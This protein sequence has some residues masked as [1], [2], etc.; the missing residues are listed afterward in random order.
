MGK[1]S[2]E[3]FI[4]AGGRTAIA[5][6]NKGLKNF[7]AAQMAATVVADI[8]RRNEIKKA[9][10]SEV[11][12]GN[13]VSAG[14][15]QNIARQVIALAQLPF[16]IPAYAVNF[17]CGSGLQSVILAAQSLLAGNTGIVIAGGTESVTQAP[18]FIIKDSPPGDSE[19]T[20]VASDIHDGLRCLITGKHMGELC[21]D[22]AQEQHIS[23]QEQDEFAVLSHQKACAAQREG[24]FRDE[25]IPLAVSPTQTFNRDQRPREDANLERLQR[26]PSAFRDQGTITAGNA[27]VPCDGAAALLLTT[28]DVIKKEKLKPLARISGYVSVGVDPAK[29]FTAAVTAIKT[30]LKKTRMS[31]Q[32]I[33]LFEICESFAAQAIYTQRAVNIPREKMNIVGGDVALGHPLGA[34]GARIL[35]TLLHALREQKKKV[36]LAAVCLGGG[37]AVAMIVEQT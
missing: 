34:A 20:T 29:T 3:I 11:F 6:P 24:K 27:S 10:I 13:T 12:L 22:L 7:T 26:L 16:P 32:D 35:V 23:R 5:S 15:G 19:N 30:C 1:K 28:A 37:G 8:V 25:I 33:D 18:K 36:G 14:Q 17:V 4:I 31:L 9:L 2:S 21:E